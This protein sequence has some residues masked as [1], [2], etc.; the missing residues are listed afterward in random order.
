MLLITHLYWCTRTLVIGYYDYHLMTLLFACFISFHREKRV[1]GCKRC[2]VYDN[3]RFPFVVSPGSPP[4]HR[5]FIQKWP[6]YLMT[7]ITVTCPEVVT[8]SDNQCSY[9]V[10][11][12]SM[13]CTVFVNSLSNTQA[14]S[15]I[16]ISYCFTFY[17]NTL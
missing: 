2:F 4:L 13:C 3:I 15:M 16:H 8:I 7:I 1:L 5:Q 9:K 14:A 11:N 6:Y 12:S 10:I 17:P